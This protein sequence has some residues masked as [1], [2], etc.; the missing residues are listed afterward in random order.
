MTL[1]VG[2]KLIKTRIQSAIVS[3]LL[4]IFGGCMVCPPV[5]LANVTQHIEAPGQS[6]VKAQQTV[7]DQDGSAWQIV[8]FRQIYPDHFDP[9]YLRLV[10]FPGAQTVD[11]EQPLTLSASRLLPPKTILTLPFDPGSST[12]NQ[13]SPESYVTQY[14]F[15]S[16]I[17]EL[18]ADSDWQ[19]E[20]PMAGSRAATLKVPSYLIQEWMMVAQRH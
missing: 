6:I 14:G 10:G 12:R 11:R 3:I 17:G 4:L 9:L 20:V 1:A 5:A 15:E 8:V 19:L 13:I 2:S 16:M 18:A 7:R